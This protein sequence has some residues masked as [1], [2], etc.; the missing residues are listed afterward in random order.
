MDEPEMQEVG[1]IIGDVLKAPTDDGV[2]QK[3]RGRVRDLME[4]FPPYPD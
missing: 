3:A 1:H 4:R 2:R